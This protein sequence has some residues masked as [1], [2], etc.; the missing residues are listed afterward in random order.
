MS[1]RPLWVKPPILTKNGVCTGFCRNSTYVLN[2]S[3]SS[4]RMQVWTRPKLTTLGVVLMP[5]PK[6]TLSEDAERIYRDMTNGARLVTRTRALDRFGSHAL[7][8][9]GKAFRAVTGS[10]LQ[11]LRSAK[12]IEVIEPSESKYLL[13]YELVSPRPLT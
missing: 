4:G 8:R 1:T 13:C 12:R 5:K 3:S 10:Q 6:P 7:S 9:E 2:G 11:E